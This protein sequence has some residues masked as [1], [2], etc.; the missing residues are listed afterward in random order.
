MAKSITWILT[1]FYGIHVALAIMV[2]PDVGQRNHSVELQSEVP[3]TQQNEPILTE[4]SERIRRLIPYMTFYV[5]PNFPV[6][7]FYNLNPIV[8]KGP[9][10]EE[11]P[12]QKDQ[13]PLEPQSKA[14]VP[15]STIR[16]IYYGEGTQKPVVPLTEELTPQQRYVAYLQ[17]QI[18]YQNQRLKQ[19]YQQ[20]SYIGP[21]STT[22]LPPVDNHLAEKVI[23]TTPSPAGYTQ[24][25]TPIS[26][27]EEVYTKIPEQLSRIQGNKPHY[28]EYL[29]Q[30]PQ[31]I[32]NLPNLIP[33]NQPYNAY[34]P[35]VYYT[36]P[37]PGYTSSINPIYRLPE[38]EPLYDE[39]PA[40]KIPVKKPPPLVRQHLTETTHNFAPVLTTYHPQNNQV[41]TPKPRYN[42]F[43]APS[44]TEK[45]KHAHR[46]RPT[47]TV[48]SI[49]A[50][51]V[52]TIHSEEPRPHVRPVL[53]ERPEQNFI[54]QHEQPIYAPAVR[55]EPIVEPVAK[56]P[57]PPQIILPEPEVVRI[58]RPKPRPQQRPVILKLRPQPNP[59][60][61]Y[62]P[63][64]R[65]NLSYAPQ[66][67]SRPTF[68]LKQQQQPQSYAELEYQTDNF[69][70]MQPEPQPSPQYVLQPKHRPESNDQPD[71]IHLTQR[72]IYHSSTSDISS[73]DLESVSKPEIRPVIVESASKPNIKPV[74]IPKQPLDS[75]PISEPSA[76]EIEPEP[77][78]VKPIRPSLIYTPRPTQPDPVYIPEPS[79]SAEESLESEKPD[80]EPEPSHPVSSSPA[81]PITED[82]EDDLAQSSLAEI[83]RKLQDTNQLPKTLTPDNIDDSIR[84]LIKILD[85]L[86][87]TQSVLPDPPQHHEE[88]KEEYIEQEIIEEPK[89]AKK[90]RPGPGTGRP[91]IDYPI[92]ADIPKTNFNC[93]EQRYKGFFGDPDTGCQVWHYCDLN[94]GQASFLCPNGT[95]FSQVAL[96]CDW[97]FNVKCSTTPQLY[98]LNERLYKYILPF[99]PKFPE[100]YSGPLVDKYL[101]L[102]FQE[103]EE[104]MRRERLKGKLSKESADTSSSAPSNGTITSESKS[105]ES[106]EEDA[107]G[108]SSIDTGLLPYSTAEPSSTTEITSNSISPVSDQTTEKTYENILPPSSTT[109]Y[110]AIAPSEL[111]GDESKSKTTVE[112]EK[113]EV[114]EIRANGDS[115]HL[116]P[117]HTF[118]AQN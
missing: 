3:I 38:I 22:A 69:E 118:V 13:G 79:A 87:Q 117:S 9:T 47:P 103:M 70:P 35:L 109:T 91:G 46:R 64:P 44:R 14:E 37:N 24:I 65:P 93:K 94:G 107:L 60:P 6:A 49:E 104:K 88:E 10:S 85:N 48:V 89:P 75:T 1:I 82:N 61:Q 11:A 56:S 58:P 29:Q 34:N 100:D 43:T 80:S 98:V 21:I 54:P 30:N 42:S 115:G 68:V 106:S 73:S 16:P 66:S 2:S 25:T 52:N 105:E 53:V 40:F 99:T 111:F 62:R 97:W 26:N 17:Q 110:A 114:I 36:T 101:A 39:V 86:K 72:P 108:N 59:E 84:T 4:K 5:P 77:R 19:Q 83:L 78:P 51:D 63:D 18:Q 96:T 32:I 12:T 113:V 45:R 15:T 76:S 28:L 50:G 8:F 116:N 74:F 95:I 57:P 81:T 7:E 33:S 41:T 102:K 23:S 31:Q 71:H 27:N 67:G 112:S 92:L 20:P 55:P 90:K